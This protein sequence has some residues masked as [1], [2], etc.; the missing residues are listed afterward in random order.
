MA[1]L[2]HTATLLHQPYTELKNE[3]KV[4][5]KVWFKQKRRQAEKLCKTPFKLRN[6]NI[7]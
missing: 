5:R 1:G 2:S 7:P 6:K 4:G 3:P